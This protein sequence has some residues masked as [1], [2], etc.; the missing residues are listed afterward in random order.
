MRGKLRTGP[1]EFRY[2]P[3]SGMGQTERRDSKFVE[4][5]SV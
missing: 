1:H 3:D 5:Q 2:G 4:T